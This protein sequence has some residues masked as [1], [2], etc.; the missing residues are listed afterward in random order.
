M[1]CIE[2]LQFP[3]AG[4]TVLLAVPHVQGRQVGPT[5]AVST[6]A[7][8]KSQ[9]NQRAFGRINETNGAGGRLTIT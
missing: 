8:S 6:S 2:P 7:E 1:T 4:D 9:Q 5:V 3:V